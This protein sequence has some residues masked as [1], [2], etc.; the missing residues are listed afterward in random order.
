MKQ[1]KDRLSMSKMKSAALLA[2]FAVAAAHPAAAITASDVMDK[3]DQKQRFGYLSGLVDMMSYQALLAGDRARAECISNAFYK[4]NDMSMRIL[5]AFGKYPAK[6]P[7][8]L[9]VVLMKRECG[10]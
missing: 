1:V 7:E 4:R 5:E 2:C 9:V 6:A 8:G 10:G 3:M